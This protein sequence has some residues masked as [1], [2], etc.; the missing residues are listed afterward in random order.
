MG[1][2]TL[3]I[4]DEIERELRQRAGELHGASKGAISKSVEEAI[5]TWLSASRR[6]GRPARTFIAISDGKRVAEGTDLRL[7]AM[8]LRSQGLDP[9]RVE[10][11]TIP[12]HPK[13]VNLG[14][15][16]RSRTK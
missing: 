12:A 13:V 5:T 11:Q 7:L 10:I 14:L 2:I 9:R 1:V 3:K 15:P 4:D 16:V 8:A 6:A